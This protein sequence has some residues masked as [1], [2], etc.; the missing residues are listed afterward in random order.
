MLRDEQDKQESKLK[1]GKNLAWKDTNS[2]ATNDTV[3][4]GFKILQKS[5]KITLVTLNK[6]TYY[7]FVAGESA[8]L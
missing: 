4:Q 7:V 3:K 5:L 1:R 6:S 8:H 2:F